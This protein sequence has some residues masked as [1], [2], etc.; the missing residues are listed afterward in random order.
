MMRLAM[1]KKVQVSA[2]SGVKGRNMCSF[3]EDCIHLKIDYYSTQL[4]FC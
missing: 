2:K 1:G 3:I 4:I